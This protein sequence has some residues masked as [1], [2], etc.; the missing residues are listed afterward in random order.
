MKSA[1]AIPVSETDLKRFIEQASGHLN[2]V[3]WIPAKE[4]L[5]SADLS[6]GRPR[7]RPS[8]VLETVTAEKMSIMEVARVISK[9]GFLLTTDLNY[10]MHTLRRGM[11]LGMHIAEAYEK[12][13]G[14][15]E[16]VSGNA[17]NRLSD[18]EKIIFRAKNQT[19]AAVAAFVFSSYIVW[20]L[21]S[22]KSEEVERV[23]A[24]IDG[25]PEMPLINAPATL[26]CLLFYFGRVISKAETGFEALK[27]AK[28]YFARVMD[29][30][31]LIKL[32][33]AEPFTSITYK[34]EG[35]DFAV[36]GFEIAS[37]AA[38]V[39]VQ[40]APTRYDEMVGNKDAIH[41]S[42]RIVQRIVLGYNPKDKLN[43]FQKLGGIARV[44]MGKGIPGTGKSKLI[45]AIATDFQETSAK[46]NRPF[47]FTPM[48]D[49]I[50]STFQG[51]SAERAMEWFKAMQDPNRI[52]YMPMDDAENVIEDRTRQG[53][54]AGVREVIGVFLRSTEGA[55]AV[56]RGNAL[57]DVMTNLPEQIDLAIMSRIQDRFDVNGARTVHDLIDQDY[58]WWQPLAKD[59]PGFIDLKDPTDYKYLVDQAAL[60]NISQL[61][62]KEPEPEGKLLKQVFFEVGREA[63]PKE[64]A[65]YGKLFA[66]VQVDFQMFSS[67]DV[68]N[69]QRAISGRLMDFDMPELWFE[70]PEAFADQPYDQRL[71]M[72][73]D[74]MR[75]NT[76]GL[77]F[78]QIRYQET[79]NYLNVMT[80]I[81][82]N[83]HNRKVEEYAEQRRIQAE[84]DALFNERRTSAQKAAAA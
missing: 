5:A 22:Y 66:R 30:I 81:T 7:Y 75:Q 53:V 14:L 77:S 84:G 79:V 34:L 6:S 43:P 57:L 63:T 82:E 80:S 83:A 20:K 50:I 58:L 29:E 13:S 68:R 35:E 17:G 49:N 24:T 65:Y 41:Q 15:G 37:V 71:A 78:S 26:K 70:K 9:E 42:R 52:V 47:L 46:F 62:K 72:V 25:L 19:K 44:R 32:D 76:K 10:L 56:D 11:Q 54:A 33:Y 38:A 40:F 64:H 31:K 67:R 23:K 73:K 3:E 16:L 60:R 4:A 36:D 45:A 59:L 28:L 1:N 21:S 51:G 2:L 61:Y 27:L 12:H 8:M 48:P 39:S 69:I 74:L 55:Y 18:N